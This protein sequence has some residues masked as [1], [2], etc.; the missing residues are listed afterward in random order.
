[1]AQKGRI[2]SLNRP[3]VGLGNPHDTTF[4]EIAYCVGCSRGLCYRHSLV[5]RRTHTSL[6][7]L[8]GKVTATSE[9]YHRL[10]KQ[11]RNN[12]DL[13]FGFNYGH[14]I[15]KSTPKPEG[16]LAPSLRL[17]WAALTFPEC[18]PIDQKRSCRGWYD[19]LVGFL[20]N[21][22]AD[23]LICLSSGS[24]GNGKRNAG[25]R[26]NGTRGSCTEDI[27]QPVPRHATRKAEARR[28]A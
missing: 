28:S 21:M 6:D 18:E 11:E 15:A 22:S 17:V 25:N 16:P 19:Q 26:D 12:F 1:M 27:Q 8:Y 9:V 10:H 4:E 13:V 3:S 20:I 5:M 14:A 2:C 7:I 24:C 23:W